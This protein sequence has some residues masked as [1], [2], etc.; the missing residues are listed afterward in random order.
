MGDLISKLSGGEVVGVLALFGVV[1]VTLT[2]IVSY[3]LRRMR[4][5]ELE[6]ALK[7]QML[8]KGMSAAEIVQVLKASKEPTAEEVEGAKD[9][10]AVRSE[11]VQSL[12]EQEMPAADIELVL[13]AL[14]ERPDGAHEKAMMIANMAEQGLKGPD[15]ARVVRA[16]HHPAATTSDAGGVVEPVTTAP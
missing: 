10:T 9:F 4:Q 1:L 14:Q 16:M 7:Q 2:A 15:I 12:V 5:T 8:D 3:Q 11:L 6:I 13:Q